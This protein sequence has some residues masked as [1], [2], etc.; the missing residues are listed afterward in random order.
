MGRGSGRDLDNNNTAVSETGFGHHKLWFFSG[1]GIGLLTTAG[2][3]VS[4]HL[5]QV[6]V[7]LDCIT[8]ES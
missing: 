4:G 1:E 5:A 2:G 7:V 8:D 3:V 6:G